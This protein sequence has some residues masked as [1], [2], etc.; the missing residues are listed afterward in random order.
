MES[1]TIKKVKG[2]LLRALSLGIADIGR[3]YKMY[4]AIANKLPYE[5][6]GLNESGVTIEE[7]KNRFFEIIWNDFFK[8]DHDLLIAQIATIKKTFNTSEDGS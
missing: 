2:N 3:R 4:C 8:A 5:E 1:V 6:P 7:Q